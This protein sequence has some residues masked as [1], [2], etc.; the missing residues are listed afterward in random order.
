MELILK[1]IINLVRDC[2]DSKAYRE[3]D[4]IR[5]ERKCYEDIKAVIEPLIHKGVNVNDNHSACL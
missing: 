3:A 2:E 4:K 5:Q 1:E